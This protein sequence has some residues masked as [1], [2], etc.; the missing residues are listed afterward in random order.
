MSLGGP[1]GWYLTHWQGRWPVWVFPAV[2]H[3][4]SCLVVGVGPVFVLIL[5]C[6]TKHY[7]NLPPSHMGVLTLRV[8]VAFVEETP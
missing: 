8:L 7:H 5:D 1:S 6:P 4:L 2:H 3:L